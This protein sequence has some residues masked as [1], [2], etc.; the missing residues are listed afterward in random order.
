M[1]LSDSAVNPVRLPLRPGLEGDCWRYDHLAKQ[2]PAMHRHAELELNFVISGQATYL[3]PDQRFDIRRHSL[4]WLFP[5][6]DH[7]LLHES[8]DFAM[9]IGV[10]RPSLIRR[11]APSAWAETLQDQAP[12]G[13]FVRPVHGA[14]ASRLDS[15][16]EEVASAGDQP[17]L[18]NTGLAYVLLSAWAAFERAAQEQSGVDL[19]PAVE[20]AIRLLR[21]ED[22]PLPVGELARRVCLSPSRLSHVFR[23]QTGLTLG[24]FRDRRRIERFL[25]ASEADRSRTLAD[26]ALDAGFGSYAQFYRVFKS[27]MGCGSGEHRIRQQEG[28]PRASA[29]VLV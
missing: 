29:A 6:Q 18:F 16:L 28:Y 12:E 10:F 15:L 21:G 22:D 20:Q 7:V 11:A 1:L 23:E 3:L 17:D 9:W 24:Q 2:Y 8:P 27:L 4:C 5:G 14:A 19:H 25:E 13:R 26:C